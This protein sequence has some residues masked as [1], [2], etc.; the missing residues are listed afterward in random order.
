MVI[1]VL[2]ST[3]MT[4]MMKTMRLFM[5]LMCHHPEV[6][7]KLHAEIDSIIGKT[8]LPLI[9]VYLKHMFYL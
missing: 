2:F 7:A 6:Q 5:L 9:S 8:T 1:G 4:E 3:G